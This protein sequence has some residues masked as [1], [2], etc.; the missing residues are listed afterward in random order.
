M[1]KSKKSNLKAKH[2][3]LNLRFY[4]GTSLGRNAMDTENAFSSMSR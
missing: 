1:N 3:I 2:C 4:F